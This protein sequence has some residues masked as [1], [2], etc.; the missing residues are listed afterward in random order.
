MYKKIKST[1]GK[2][3]FFIGR[4]PEIEKRIDWKRF[5]PEPYKAVLLISADFELAWAWRYT[6]SSQDPIKKALTKARL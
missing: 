3:N 6:K 2:L 1:L 4:S 5:I